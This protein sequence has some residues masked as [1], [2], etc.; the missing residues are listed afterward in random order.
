ML[1]NFRKGDKVWQRVHVAGLVTQEEA[2]V[3]KVDEAGVWLDNGQGNDPDGPFVDGKL[4]FHS[5][6]LG[7]QTIVPRE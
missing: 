5:D 6:W 4:T 1:T 7:Y 2:E 3:L